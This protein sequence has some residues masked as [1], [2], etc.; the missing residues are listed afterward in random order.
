MKPKRVARQFAGWEGWLAP[1]PTCELAGLE[2]FFWIAEFYTNSRAS[3][4]MNA[5]R[6]ECYAKN[7]APLRTAAHDC[8]M[9]PIV[10][11]CRSVLRVR[12]S[13]FGRGSR[14]V[15]RGISHL[16][17]DGVNPSVAIALAF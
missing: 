2:P 16:E 1:A 5:P 7:P 14:D 13:D 12:H 3:V 9:W 10:H 17:R 4:L 8:V 15:A 6:Y 11:C